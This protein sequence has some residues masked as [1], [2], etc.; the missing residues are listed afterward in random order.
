MTAA[1]PDLPSNS[2]TAG[3]PTAG[4]DPDNSRLPGGGSHRPT[5]IARLSPVAVWASLTIAAV[6]VLVS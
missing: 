6:Y 4:G 1:T 2:R 5:G 3:F